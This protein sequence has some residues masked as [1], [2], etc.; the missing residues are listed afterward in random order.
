[1]KVNGAKTTMVCVSGAQSYQAESFINTS[2]GTVV[3]SGRAMM[4]LGFHMSPRPGVHEHVD[5]LCKRMRRQYWVLYHLRRA[6]FTEEELAKVYRTCLLPILDY[7]AVVYHPMM[8]DDQDQRIER[9][10]SSALRCIYG[11]NTSYARMR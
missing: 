9:L 4:I 7:C 2:A 5:V 11:H 8:T 1:M 6:G 3:E 10:Q